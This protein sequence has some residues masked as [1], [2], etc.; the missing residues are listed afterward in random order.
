MAQQ[1]LYSLLIRLHS[2]VVRDFRFIEHAH[3]TLALGTKCIY[4]VTT[5]VIRRHRIIH[6][7]CLLTLI[8]RQ[9]CQLVDEFGN[10]LRTVLN[11]IT[12]FLTLLGPQLVVLGA[13]DIRESFNRIQRRTQL[14][15]DIRDKLILHVEGLLDLF[16]LLLKAF[17]L[18]LQT[19]NT[20]T[21]LPYDNG[22]YKNESYNYR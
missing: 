13:K 14:V 7:Q 3:A 18:L 20:P 9:L 6:G 5:Q 4:H 8:E 2:I 11:H 19:F 10:S 15:R 22:K 17:V 1:C 12:E 21:V 16:T